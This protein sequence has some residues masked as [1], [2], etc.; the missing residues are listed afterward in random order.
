VLAAI[1]PGPVASLH[2]QAL[3]R[4][5]VAPGEMITVASRRGRISLQARADDGTPPG[6]VFI[7]R[8]V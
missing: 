3:A 8:K 4:L 2:T 1:E 7:A 6:A 5:G